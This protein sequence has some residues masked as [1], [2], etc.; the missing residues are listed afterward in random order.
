MQMASRNGLGSCWIT[1]AKLWQ[2]EEGVPWSG[3]GASCRLG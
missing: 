3:I 1:T 2:K